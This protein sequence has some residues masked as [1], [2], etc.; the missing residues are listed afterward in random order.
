MSNTVQIS[1]RDFLALL[2]PS[3]WQ[4]VL[5]CK[6]GAMALLLLT[7]LKSKVFQVQ[8]GSL[9]DL[10]EL[11]NLFRDMLRTLQEVS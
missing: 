7:W 6:L 8:K 3:T 9:L 10:Q 4:W 2:M 1:L 5:V 11:Q